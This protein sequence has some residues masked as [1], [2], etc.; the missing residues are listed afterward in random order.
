M[1]VTYPLRVFLLLFLLTAGCLR[2]LAQQQGGTPLPLI[3][4]NI[5]PPSPEGSAL[6]K[7][8]D[9]PIGMFT[10]NPNFT[11]D[12]YK[13]ATKHLTLPISLNY[14]ANG[15]K[16]DDVSSKA[17]MSWVLNCGGMISRTVYGKPDFDE[18]IAAPAPPDQNWFNAGT[19]AAL[20]GWMQAVGT[21]TN[22]D[23]QMDAFNY[24]FNGYTGK[25]FINPSTGVPII[26]P[27]SN[28][29]IQYSFTQTNWNF[30]ITTPD[31]TQYYFGGY[32]ATEYTEDMNTC[33][34]SNKLGTVPMG[35]YLTKIQSATDPS[36]SLHF[37]Y[38]AD[39]YEYATGVNE[40]A[41]YIDAPSLTS[42][43]TC[44]PGGPPPLPCT[45]GPT[46]YIYGNPTPTNGQLP[47]QACQNISGVQGVCLE[48]ITDGKYNLI[49]FNYTPKPDVTNDSLVAGIT[50]YNKQTG[51]KV[52]SYNFT[53]TQATPGFTGSGNTYSV[54]AP[55]PFL[56]EV[57]ELDNGGNIIRPWKFSYT[58]FTGLPPRLSFSQDYWGYF[59]GVVNPSPIPLPELGYNAIAAGLIANRNPD[60]N[61]AGLGMLNQITYPTGGY[62]NIYYEGNTQD[63]TYTIGSQSTSVTYLTGQQTI[64]VSSSNP[65]NATFQVTSAVPVT[66]T[67]TISC[68][69]SNG[70]S[71]PVEPDA[72]YY[73]ELVLNNVDL[74]Q[75]TYQRYN[76]RQEEV[77]VVVNTTLQPGVY[78]LDVLPNGN[79]VMS[80]S[81]SPSST[82]DTLYIVNIANQVPMTAASAFT[83]G[84]MRVQRTVSYD[85]TAGRSTIKHYYYDEAEFPVTPIYYNHLMHYESLFEDPPE[86]TNCSSV[87]N[88]NTSAGYNQFYSCSLNNLYGAGNSGV[89]YTQVRESFGDNFE[90]GGILHKYAYNGFIPLQFVFGLGIPNVV[91]PNLNWQNGLETFTEDYKIVNG[92][93]V[94]VQTKTMSYIIDSR[95]TDTVNQYVVQ[96]IGNNSAGNTSPAAISQDYNVAEVS[97]ITQWQYKNNEIT[98]HYDLNGNLTVADT[99]NY[100]YDNA[101]H[102]MLTRTQTNDSKGE[103]VRNVWRYPQDQ[104]GFAL[105]ASGESPAIS[106]LIAQG[107]IGAPIEQENDLN[108]QVVKLAHNAYGNFS[109]GITLSQQVNEQN[110]TGPAYTDYTVN[111]YT[112]TGDMS[113]LLPKDGVTQLFIWDYLSSYPIAKVINADSTSI[114]YTSFEAN[115]SGNWTIGSTARSAG[116][117]TGSQYYALSNNISKSGLNASSSYIVSYWS[118]GAAY[119]IPGTATGYPVRGKTENA[120]N[121]T[122]T[123]YEHLVTGESTIQVNGTGGIDELR[124]YPQGAQ[125]TTFTYAPLI[126]LTSQCDVDNRVTYYEYDAFSRLADVK[127][128]DQN[129]IKRYCYNYNG[130]PGTCLLSNYGI[131][132][133]P[134][135]V[136]NGTSESGT[137][138][139]TNTS[140]GATYSFT[141]G[142]GSSG[143]VV[144]SVPE[145]TYNMTITPSA[146]S[147]SY[148]VDYAVNSSILESALNASFTSVSGSTSI[149]VSMTPLVTVPVT[150]TNTT[151]EHMTLTFTNSAGS[152]TLQNNGGTGVAGYIPQGVY[153]VTV[154]PNSA[155]NTYPMIFSVGGSSQSNW[156]NVSYSNVTMNS[157]TAISINPFPSEQVVVSNS[158]NQAISLVFTDQVYGGTFSYTIAPGASNSVPG[159]IPADKYTVALSV[160]VATDTY[161]IVFNYD[162]NSVSSTS[163]ASWSSQT[164][165]S[166]V[167]IHVS[168]V[169]TNQVVVTNT[170][171]QTL[172]VKFADLTYGA[173][174][175]YNVPA[176]T[177][178]DLVG[179]IP[180]SNYTITLSNSSPVNTYPIIFTMDGSVQTYYGPVSYGGSV[181][182]SS[183]VSISA[184]PAIATVVGT[185]NTGEEIGLQFVN[186][187]TGYVYTFGLPTSSLN[188]TLGTMPQGTYNVF[189]TPPSPSS[190]KPIE[191]YLNTSYQTYYGEVEFGGA[192]LTSSVTVQ[193]Y[194]DY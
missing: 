83:A 20:A 145:G 62:T 130:Q 36:D 171:N 110:G 38:N 14:S 187:S 28:I 55:R 2:L 113:Q 108:G 115:G 97:Y 178:N 168:P 95:N 86:G 56:M 120:G 180:S 148:F 48:Q 53:Y 164:I 47:P 40:T 147:A 6:G 44:N 11:V 49:Q 25:F 43:I 41:T 116:G 183:Q 127:D 139:L 51:T 76:E 91:A 121:G 67:E 50:V 29:S 104:S 107:R 109:N 61:S 144:G 190:L 124:L 160:P 192:V 65:T 96:Q 39:F 185:N 99:I 119:T 60:Y 158:T 30:K 169:Q 175:L 70:G 122:W 34:G 94:P 79:Y 182:I 141:A 9:L 21:S 81:I 155:V 146:P 80:M 1:R 33:T 68:N 45:C 98:Q 27:Y 153:A 103:Q 138:S 114:A 167:S 7:F 177:S 71:C 17:G 18:F 136:T 23:N 4:P 170:T 8:G 137:L 101:T 159:Y 156:T 37:S 35:W 31:G 172:T 184:V 142:A 87:A 15:I 52:K 134:V 117:I 3:T 54:S 186:T 26:A 161:P 166:Q 59:N 149:S 152:F 88:T 77:E 128:Q 157:Q 64:A 135:T 162:G 100:F 69:T 73:G 16:V 105:P 176:G 194:K 13:V 154:A 63:S 129:V 132:S 74:V 32:G 89:Y 191:W 19:D 85:P 165:N 143:A 151:T 112:P 66:I 181:P 179:Y 126:G 90:D 72:N 12:L 22:I 140:S 46:P 106:S 5:L 78:G 163:G 133:L 75:A 24:N 57:D 118:N 42:F 102:A 188:V 131:P 150:V 92:T 82:S 10:G 58:D 174:Y 125:M 84:G 123:Y 193:C 93:T 173:T 189:M 111:R